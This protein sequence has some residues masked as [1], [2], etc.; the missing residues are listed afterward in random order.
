MPL[1]SSL[2]SH[3]VMVTRSTR[4][5]KLDSEPMGICA[6]TALAWRRSFMVS[7]AWK[8]SAPTRSYLLMN[9]MRGTPYVVA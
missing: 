1:A 6:A 4:P 5:Q 9:A 8:K 3:A 7:M 2:K